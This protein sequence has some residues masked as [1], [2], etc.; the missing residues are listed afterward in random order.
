MRHAPR[1]AYGYVPDRPDDRDYPYRPTGA[2]RPKSVDLRGHMPPV[3]DQGQLGSCTAFALTGAVGF[4]HGFVGSQLWLYYKERLL[5]HSTRRDAGAE[6]R[7]G[8]KVLAKQGLPP[9]A[10]W[11]Y[12]IAKFR[13]K[14][15]AAAD[16]AARQELVS[17]YHRLTGTSDYLDCLAGG[18]PFVIGIT[19]FESFE[20][21]AVAAS[22]VVPMPGPSEQSLGGHAVCVCG[23]DPA[24]FIVRNSWGPAWGQHGYFHLPTAYLADG[25][26]AGDAW[27]ITGCPK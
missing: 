5:E 3:W 2:A 23:Y 24:G 7:D 13:R 12:D 25:I 22:G 27:A 9:E 8:V 19:V 15:P 16:A 10:V 26:L 14:P 11:P 21:D 18:S 6:I 20:S 4:L 17:A 1:R